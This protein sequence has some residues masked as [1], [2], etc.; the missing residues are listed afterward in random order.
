MCPTGTPLA[1][2][3]PPKLRTLYI[4]DSSLDT[5]ASWVVPEQPTMLRHLPTPLGEEGRRGEGG[6]RPLRADHELVIVVEDWWF[7]AHRDA[8]GVAAFLEHEVATLPL[9]FDALHVVG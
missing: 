1:I 5:V 3:H 2:N 8:A 4:P 7:E 9:C 6:A